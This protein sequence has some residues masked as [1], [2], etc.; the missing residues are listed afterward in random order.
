MDA[1]AEADSRAEI[2]QLMGV[3]DANRLAKREEII[4]RRALEARREA[5]DDA[6]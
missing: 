1:K 6:P 4:A 2:T 3:I 5:R